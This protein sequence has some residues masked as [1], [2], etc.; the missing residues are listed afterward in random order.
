MKDLIWRWFLDEY[1]F[2]PSSYL[3]DVRTMHLPSLRTWQSAFHRSLLVTGSMPVEGSSRKTIGGSPIRAMV[4]LNLRLFP[5]LEK[6]INIWWRLS[7]WATIVVCM[8][9][10][11]FT[12]LRKIL[13]IQRL[14]HMSVACV[15]FFHR[16]CENNELTVINTH[17]SCQCN[18]ENKINYSPLTQN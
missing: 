8:C 14:I 4:V 13:N 10:I 11:F 2:L 15:E 5:P 12:K 17:Q 3:C 9:G 6:K 7:L 16:M 18:H 1:N